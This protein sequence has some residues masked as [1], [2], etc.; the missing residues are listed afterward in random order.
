MWRTFSA[1]W[2]PLNFASHLWLPNPPS[3]LVH[4]AQPIVPFKHA[5]QRFQTFKTGVYC[6]RFHVFKLA[7]QQG[8]E[9]WAT[10]IQSCPMA[11][12]LSYLP[13]NTRRA[14]LRVHGK[15]DG[16]RGSCFSEIHRFPLSLDSSI[17]RGKTSEAPLLVAVGYGDCQDDE[18]YHL[19]PQGVQALQ[20][21]WGPGR[22]MLRCGRD[23]Q[24]TPCFKNTLVHN[25][26]VPSGELT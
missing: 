4:Q 16:S 19:S 17:F 21:F 9:F 7:F 12:G 22:L 11:C 8:V 25:F 24:H 6:L 5:F 1:S 10:R 3:Y 15:M 14:F 23:K 26:L 13:H 2:R 20:C 18:I